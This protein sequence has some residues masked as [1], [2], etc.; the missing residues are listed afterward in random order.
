MARKRRK[1]KR[2]TEMP[3][4]SKR[5]KKYRKWSEESMSGVVKA[6]I[7]GKMGGNGKSGSRSAWDPK[8]HSQG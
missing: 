6:I 2:S 5:P 8:V 3:V 4:V 1:R 7:D